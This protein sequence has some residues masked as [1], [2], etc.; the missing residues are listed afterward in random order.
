M[1]NENQKISSG[2]HKVSILTG[3]MMMEGSLPGNERAGY[4]KIAGQVAPIE[5][6][7]GKKIWPGSSLKNGFIYMFRNGVC[8]VNQRDFVKLEMEGIDYLKNLKGLWVDIPVKISED[9]IKNVKP[10]QF[11]LST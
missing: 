10:L 4:P 6:F 8:A 5:N 7:F 1:T 9:I 11:N 2:N 3:R